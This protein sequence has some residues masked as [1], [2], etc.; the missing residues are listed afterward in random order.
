MAIILNDYQ[1]SGKVEEI[2][3]PGSKE[4]YEIPDAEDVLTVELL[5]DLQ[6]GDYSGIISL[7]PDDAQIL[8]KKLHLAQVKQFIQAWTG[9]A[10]N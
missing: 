2:V 8:F 5:E 10:K 6:R 7:F 4:R 1:P 9:S 3:F